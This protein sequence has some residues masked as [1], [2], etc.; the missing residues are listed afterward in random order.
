MARQAES[1]DGI[2]DVPL[3]PAVAEALR[4]LLR[5]RGP[6]PGDPLFPSERGNPQE[7][8]V[9]LRVWLK[10]A[11]RRA[12]LDEPGLGFHALRHTAASFWLKGGLDIVEVQRLLGHHAASFT[13][14]TY[15][16]LIGADLP[17]CPGSRGRPV[18]P[19]LAA[20]R[21]SSLKRPMGANRRS[22]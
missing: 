3:T 11:L 13:L 21:R 5:E 17:S 20:G 10:P 15:V 6:R 2:R 4:V 16:H 14:D 22:G 9:A 7:P 12:G 1:R 19:E 8:T 18:R